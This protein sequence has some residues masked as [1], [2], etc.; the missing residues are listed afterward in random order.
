GPDLDGVLPLH[1]R[2]QALV[3]VDG[4]AG[5]GPEAVGE[6]VALQH[7]LDGDPAGQRQDVEEVP[8]AEPLVVVTDLGPGDVDDLA[9][10]AEVATGVGLDLLLGE[11]GPGLVPAAGVAHQGG[12]VANDQHRLVPQLLEQAEL[13]QGHRVPEVDI[14]AGRVDAVLDAQGPALAD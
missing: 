7:A 10:L 5:R 9:D 13:A 3:Q 11:P 14:A 1:E 12:A 8:P 2:I 4:H 6:V